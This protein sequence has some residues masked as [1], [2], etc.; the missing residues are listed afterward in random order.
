MGFKRTSFLLLILG[1]I[2][3]DTSGQSLDCT[4][5]FSVVTC[6]FNAQNCA[7]Y[8]LTLQIKIFD[9]HE[10]RTGP[11]IQCEDGRCCCS[12]EG[13]FMVFG[14]THTATVWK[15]NKS[16]ESKDFNV[17][18]SIKPKAPTIRSVKESNGNFEVTW[19][20]NMESFIS[21]TM[22]A[23]LTYHKKGDRE[24][25]VSE[26]IKPSTKDKLHY[27]EILGRHL[28]PST[29]Y[30]VSVKSYTNFSGKFSE[31]SKEMEFTTAMSPVVLPLT[32]IICLCLAAVLI[33][34]AIYVSYVK[35]KT[36]WW[37]V[38]SKCPNPKLG[39]IYP[40][41][42]KVLK[43]GTTNYSIVCVEPFVPDDNKS[44][45]K[46]SPG[47]GSSG[48]LDQSSGISTGSSCI[49]YPDTLPER[50]IITGVSDAL[51]KA[52]SNI[53]PFSTIEETNKDS[54]LSSAPYQPCQ[55]DDMSSGAVSFIN[56]TYSIVIPSVPHQ[57][58]TNSS[59]VQ[60]QL[61]ISCDFAHHRRNIGTCVDPP[62]PS[63]LP[64][65]LPPGVPCPMPTDMSYQQCNA[66]S[67]GGS[68]AEARSLSST[69]SGTKE[70][71][72]PTAGSNSFPPVEDDYQPFQN[73]ASQPLMIF[74]ESADK[75]VGHLNRYPEE[76]F[77]AMP[78]CLSSPGVAC[79]IN[80]AQDGA[81][82][83]LMPAD[84]SSPLMSDPGYQRV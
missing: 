72:G 21:I 75:K 14:D 2:A 67:G 52:L 64:I 22:K 42:Q 69:S 19:N 49:S 26:F 16:L 71:P 20:T 13:G 18:L 84:P 61:E 38:V 27:F 40:S 62:A 23:N 9:I 58:P 78:Q 51:K 76:L 48:S 79:L 57:I 41:T 47:N 46:K 65:N 55:A 45:L 63:C 30:V 37:V 59:R 7:E 50:D 8:S 35:V 70:T 29:T 80:D 4:N 32:V 68:Y 77:T 34:A 28:E 33:T 31:S 39:V 15:G 12:I 60:T 10:N 25:Q 53:V 3:T 1:T 24:K 66:D 5:D 54:G 11:F 74:D 81:P 43:P 44:W 83:S 73:L 36:K 17:K 6:Q 56:E 82:I